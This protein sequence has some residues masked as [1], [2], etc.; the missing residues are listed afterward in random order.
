VVSDF[1]NAGQGQVLTGGTP[2]GMIL[3]SEDGPFYPG[4]FADGFES[5]EQSAWSASVP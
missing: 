3:Y 5:G 2:Q 4:I 1:T